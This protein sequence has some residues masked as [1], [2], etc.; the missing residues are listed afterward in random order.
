MPNSAPPSPGPASP[1]SPDRASWLLRAAFGAAVLLQFVVLYL[2]QTPDGTPST[3]G[4]DKAVHLLIFAL[5]MLTGRLAGIRTR[6]LVLGLLVHAGLSELVQHTLLP[7]R[8]GDLLDILANIAGTGLGWY[9]A[10]MIT[11]HRLRR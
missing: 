6:P 1:R 2:P 11:R 9:V 4:S 5:V 7:A 10:S 8:A 3:P